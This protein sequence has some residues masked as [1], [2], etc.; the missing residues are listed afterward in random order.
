MP[1][2]VRRGENI[3]REL[4][5][6][7]DICRYNVDISDVAPIDCAAYRFSWFYS[8]LRSMFYRPRSIEH[9]PQSIVQ[10][11]DRLYVDIRSSS[12]QYL[13]DLAP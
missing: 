7:L 10:R 2:E 5:P 9:R 1:H 6:L 4:D 11:F 12:P 3:V 8:R 13:F